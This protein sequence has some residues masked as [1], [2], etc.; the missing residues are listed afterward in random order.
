MAAARHPSQT[1][2]MF[3]TLMGL[4]RCSD[5][6]T[7][8]NRSR[9]TPRGL[10]G[11]GERKSV[12]PIAARAVDE[13]PFEPRIR[14][15]ATSWEAWEAGRKQEK[16]TV[17]ENAPWDLPRQLDDVA[18]RRSLSRRTARTLCAAA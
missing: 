6:E 16:M 12:E 13:D 4:A 1:F 17:S 10:F 5:V 18:A 14:A 2:S 9:S 11:V 15:N 7:D 8:A 3:G